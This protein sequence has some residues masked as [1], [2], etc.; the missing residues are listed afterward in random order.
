MQQDYPLYEEMVRRGS[1]G[2]W[3]WRIGSWLYYTGILGIVLLLIIWPVVFYF[4][5][6]DA[7]LLFFVLLLLMAAIFT[8]GNLLKRASYRIALGEGIDVVK[9]F[10]QGEKGEK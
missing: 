2:R 7:G 1:R 3:F 10:Q 6:S 4:R 5:I 9:Y 8:T